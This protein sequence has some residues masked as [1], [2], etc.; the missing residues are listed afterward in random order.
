MP[1][2]LLGAF[3]MD[4]QDIF[5]MKRAI[6]LASN[7][8]GWVNPNPLVGAVVVKNNHIIGEG[9]HERFGGPHAERNALKNCTEDTRGADLY[10]TLEPCCHFGKTP[11]CTEAVISYGIRRV[12]VGIEDPNPLVAGKGIS[13]LREAGIEVNVGICRDEIIKQNRIFLKYITTGLPWVMLKYAM[14]LDGK[15]ASYL[16]DSKW[17]TGEIAR[18][19]VH[20]LRAE[21]MAVALGIGSVRAD[22]PL[23]NCRLEG[24]FRQ[25]VRIIVDSKATI[26]ECII[27]SET[28]GNKLIYTAK[29]YRTIVVHTPV[30][31]A[32]RLDALR[33][34]GVETLLCNNVDEGDCG[35]AGEAGRIGKFGHD[36]VP[37]RRVD[38]KDMLL[39]IGKLGIDSVVVEG[40]GNLNASLIECG[41]V[42]EVIAFVA[43]KIIGGSG[44]VSPVEGAG[45]DLMSNA[46]QLH[47]VVSDVVGED[48]YIRGIVK[49]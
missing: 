10:V 13:I 3:F 26:A 1:R 24:P 37:E 7:G 34:A 27:S 46:L 9:W 38:V 48:F 22:N 11:P 8:L 29:Q 21:N 33:D 6:S 35:Y 23:L 32:E 12:F 44:A 18:N 25:P 41:C 47:D 45:I 31:S 43:P 17:V 14:T 15:I 28:A 5:Y 39:K 16:G 42:D 49:K 4:K 30:A 19:M 20:H 2:I 40:G 36:G